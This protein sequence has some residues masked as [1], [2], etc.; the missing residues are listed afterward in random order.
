MDLFEAVDRRHSYRGTFAPTPV[1]RE[2]LR[3]DEVAVVLVQQVRV[4]L[5][6]LPKQPRAFKFVQIGAHDGV[7]VAPD[8]SNLSDIVDDQVRELR[9]R[10][11]NYI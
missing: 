7:R 10:R 9:K 5:E 1:P 2:H 11:R 3:R 8:L 4:G 6:T